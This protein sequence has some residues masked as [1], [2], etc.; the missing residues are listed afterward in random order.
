MEAII[1]SIVRYTD[2]GESVRYAVEL[3]HGLDHLPSKA[4]V[5]VKPNIVHWTREVSFSKWG[6]VTTS[7]VIG[8]LFSCL[9]RG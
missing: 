3:A 6:V 4:K 9:K 1:V 2:P 5:F 8:I 7:R